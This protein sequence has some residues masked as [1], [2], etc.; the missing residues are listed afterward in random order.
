MLCEQRLNT[1][2]PTP[3]K[4]RGG[5]GGGGGACDSDNSPCLTTT[6]RPESALLLATR[7]DHQNP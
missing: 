6:L 5:G 3:S 7:Q 4:A 1:Y 2:T